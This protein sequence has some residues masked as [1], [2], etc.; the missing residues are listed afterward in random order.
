MAF[1]SLEITPVQYFTQDTVQRS[2]IYR[3]FSTVDNSATTS[4]LYDFD[5]IKQDLINQFYVKRGERVMNPDFGTIIWD[6]LFDPFTA[7]V[8]QEISDDLDRIL[9]SDPR[10]VPTD[11]NVVEAD[12]G[13]LLEVTLQHVSSNQV[14]TMKLQFDKDAGLTAE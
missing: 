5:L 13:I 12:Y 9:N 14:A 8:K 7:S 6:I 3:G 1:K 4:K 11:I 2:Q 10:V